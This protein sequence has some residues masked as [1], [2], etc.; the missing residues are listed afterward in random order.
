MKK[1]F[2]LTLLSLCAISWLSAQNNKTGKDPVGK[3]N[4]QAPYA[5]EGFTGGI[6]EIKTV[7]KKLST[8]MIFSSENKFEGDRVTLK[9]DSLKFDIYVEGED[10][11]VLLKLDGETKMSGKAVYSEGEVPLTLRREAKKE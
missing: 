7:E 10:V 4:F 11:A 6:I 8:T 2:L 9:N 1:V 3:W 5:P